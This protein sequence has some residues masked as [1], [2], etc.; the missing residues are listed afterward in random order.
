LYIPAYTSVRVK[1]RFQALDN[2]VNQ[3]GHILSANVTSV[4]RNV[5]GF[6]KDFYTTSLISPVYSTVLA[7]PFYKE[8]VEIDLG[9]VTNTC[10]ISFKKRKTFS[11]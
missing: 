6:A 5:D 3:F 1:Y 4:G 10:K 7:S 8:T 11:C 2:S 9:I